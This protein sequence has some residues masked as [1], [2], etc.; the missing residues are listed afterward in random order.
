MDRCRAYFGIRVEQSSNVVATNHHCPCGLAFSE[1][2]EVRSV[3][4]IGNR[5]IWEILPEVFED[6]DPIDDEDNCYLMCYGCGR[7]FEMLWYKGT[8]FRQVDRVD[9]K[10]MGHITEATEGLPWEFT[11]GRRKWRVLRHFEHLGGVYVLIDRRDP[12]APRASSQIGLFPEHEG[13]GNR[14]VIDWDHIK[15]TLSGYGIEMENMFEQFKR[16]LLD[17][18]AP[19]K[20]IVILSFSDLPETP[21]MPWAYGNRI[22]ED[23]EIET[24]VDDPHGWICP[25][26]EEEEWNI[27]QR[28]EGIGN[29]H[30]GWQWIDPLE[31]VF[32]EHWMCGKCGRV[33]LLTNGHK[34]LTKI[35]HIDPKQLVVEDTEEEYAES[36]RGHFYCAACGHVPMMDWARPIQGIGDRD[37]GWEPGVSDDD[38]YQ[39]AYCTGCKRVFERESP[40]R[41][42]GRID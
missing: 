36:D 7:I 10:T 41:V 11:D 19:R 24:V 23:E 8:N 3:E 15:L 31:D 1:A 30:V 5:T 32:Y 20:E 14:T 39:A 2:A 22:T 25:C 29:R 34:R 9:P 40:W 4:G 26:G 18:D 6:D 37:A 17:R 38:Q 28:I 27:V 12:D 21:V 13:I 35:D 16:G 42:I 33:F